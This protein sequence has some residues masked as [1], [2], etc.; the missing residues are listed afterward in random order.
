MAQKEK[1]VQEEAGRKNPSKDEKILAAIGYLWILCLLPLLGKRQSE[2]AQF[3]GKQGLV[4]TITSFIVWLVAWV[5][6]IGWIVGFFG[7]IGLLVLAV[8]GIQ[9]AMQ[10][11]YWEM[12]VL[13]KYARQIKL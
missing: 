9:S 4:L 13:V 2:F 3:H 6:L 8:L 11:K 12:P 10:G 1:I 5:P 7:T